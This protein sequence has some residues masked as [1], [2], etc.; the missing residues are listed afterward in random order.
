M[1]SHVKF[2]EILI[3]RYLKFITLNAYTRKEKKVDIDEDKPKEHK[4]ED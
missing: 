4:W 3:K 2:Y 1:I